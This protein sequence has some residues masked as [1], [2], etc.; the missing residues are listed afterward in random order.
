MRFAY[1]YFMKPEPERVRAVAPRH[2][3]YWQGLDLA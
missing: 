1:F 3:S 2:A